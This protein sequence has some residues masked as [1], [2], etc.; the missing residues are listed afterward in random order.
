MKDKNLANTFEQLNMKN[1]QS[2]SSK[3]ELDL[4]SLTNRKAVLDLLCSLTL[5]QNEHIHIAKESETEW[6][7]QTTTDPSKKQTAV[8]LTTKNRGVG[9]FDLNW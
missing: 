5:K 3:K 4:H 9:L 7:V 1:I 8:K 6:T 2:V